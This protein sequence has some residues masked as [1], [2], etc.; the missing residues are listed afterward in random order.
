MRCLWGQT[1]HY[2]QSFSKKN[3]LDIALEL[4]TS[5][6][7]HRSLQTHS[8]S[9]HLHFTSYTSCQYFCDLLSALGFSCSDLI[10]GGALRYS[11]DS[12]DFLIIHH[13]ILSMNIIVRGDEV[14][15]VTTVISVLI[16]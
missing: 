16:S 4:L 10:M 15:V 2:S 5:Q 6:T 13:L 12:M 9:L 8:I 3:S 14:K 1:E 7:L 11:Y